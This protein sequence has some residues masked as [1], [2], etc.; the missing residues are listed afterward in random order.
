MEVLLML[1]AG[2]ACLLLVLW[3]RADS[4]AGKVRPLENEVKRLTQALTDAAATNLEARRELTESAAQEIT[5]LKDEL[6]ASRRECSDL[7]R[8]ITRAQWTAK[9]AS[10][11]SGDEPY[12]RTAGN[13][14][15]LNNWD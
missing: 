5:L 9:A 3:Q 7:K 8:Q 14:H 11:P 1:F 10:R 2:A 15:W 13:E 6:A 12:D 4:Q